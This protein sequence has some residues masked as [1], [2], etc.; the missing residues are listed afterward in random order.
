MKVFIG[1]DKRETIAYEVCKYSINNRASSNFDIK[2]LIQKDMRQKG[3]YYRDIDP[4]SSTEFTFTRFLVPFLMNYK[5]W[6]LFID[7]D[8]VFLDDIKNLFD[9]TDDKYAIMCVKHDYEIN[10]EF[11]MDGKIQTIYPRKNWS[12]VMLFNCGHPS[13]RK[14]TPQI[15]NT[16]SGKYLHRFSWLKDEE[17]GE[18]SKEWN[19]LVGVYKEPDDGIPKVLHYTNGG[20][21]FKDYFNTDYHTVWKDEYKKYTGQEFTI[22]DVIDK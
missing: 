3:L 8:I 19:W 4:L 18:I 17:I 13:N 20:P 11:K 6:A 2:P 22:N 1:W 7:C 14:L 21:Y 12:S 9:I 16:E 10:N 15:V 5:D